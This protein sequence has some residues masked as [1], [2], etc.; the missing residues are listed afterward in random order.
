MLRGSYALKTNT[1]MPLIDIWAARYRPNFSA[2][3]T[4]KQSWRIGEISQCALASRRRKTCEKLHNQLVIHACKLAAVRTKD[5]YADL[6]HLDLKQI[7]NLADLFSPVYLQLLEIYQTHLSTL[8]QFESELDPIPLNYLDKIIGVPDIGEIARV[9][10]PLLTELWSQS[11]IADSWKTLGFITTQINLTNTL[12][13]QDLDP[14]EQTLIGPYLTFLEEHMVM[15]WQRLCTAAAGPKALAV[16]KH[17]LPI[18]PEIA[19]AAHS[20]WCQ[21]FPYYYA[22][23]G[24]LEHPIVKYSSLRDFSMFQ[25]YLWLS[26]LQ[27]SADV[28]ETELV[29]LARVVY[30]KLG[31]PWEMTVQG[32]QL[33]IDEVWTRLQPWE[34]RLVEP[35]AAAMVKAFVHSD[36]TLEAVLKVL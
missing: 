23:R 31:I 6:R 24:R 4:S 9:L 15:P 35:H 32:T 33:L 2:L 34:Q 12:L 13:L 11:T 21:D 10:E 27:G 19:H 26:F 17:M 25:V 18:I 3:E 28:I 7:T 8:S 1:V 20:Q 29:V 5:L 36:S 22:R 14:M 16:V 30:G